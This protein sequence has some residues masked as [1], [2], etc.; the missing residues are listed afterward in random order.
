[1]QVWREDIIMGLFLISSPRMAANSTQSARLLS[2]ASQHFLWVRMSLTPAL[3]LSLFLAPSISLYLS[4]QIVVQALQ[5]REK[6]R[7][8]ER[9]IER[10]RERVQCA[11][12]A[13]EDE[14]GCFSD[15]LWLPERLTRTQRWDGRRS[16]SPG[17]WMKGTARFVIFNFLFFVVVRDCW[18][19]TLMVVNS[20]DSNR[21][22]CRMKS[23]LDLHI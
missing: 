21:S 4:L 8:K 2:S 10:G 3:F 16:R 5:E 15:I 11:S 9:K 19:F 18:T 6:E 23:D 1:M 14:C 22:A 7:Q 20:Y 12:G 13:E 17:L